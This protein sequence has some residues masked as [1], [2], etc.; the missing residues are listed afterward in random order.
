[1][2]NDVTN[3][4]SAVRHRVTLKPLS[5]SS[6]LK[7]VHKAAMMSSVARL[8]ACLAILI[9]T[10]SAHAASLRLTFD[11]AGATVSGVTPRQA[12]AWMVVT[13]KR[14][15][16]HIRVDKRQALIV[17]DGS[18]N[19]RF[20]WPGVDETLAVWTVVDVTTGK[21]I[22]DSGKVRNFRGSPARNAAVKKREGGAAA[23][24]QVH[25]RV[26]ELM[27]VRRGGGAWSARSSDGS[28]VDADGVRDGFAS[29]NMSDLMPIGASGPPP[30]E[31][32]PADVIVAIDPGSMQV[33]VTGAVE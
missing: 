32:H 27:Y 3:A 25:I 13:R 24:G 26:A 5:E 1:L 17:A 11:A 6:S 9:G 23:R 2:E 14:V 30:D 22:T 16:N 31:P 29:W 15:D 18:G 20:S 8:F 10:F 12:T 7:S 33:Y 19:A 4:C 28:T 21:V